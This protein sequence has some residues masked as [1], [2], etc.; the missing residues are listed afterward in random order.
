MANMQAGEKQIELLKETRTA[1][2]ALELAINI[3]VG[4]QNQFKISGK[5]AYTVSNQIANPSINSI[6]NSWNRTKSTT[7]N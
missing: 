6:Q 4:I 1:K 2:K 5:G 3:E 7:N